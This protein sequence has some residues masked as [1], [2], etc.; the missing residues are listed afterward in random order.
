MRNASTSSVFILT[1]IFAF[2]INFHPLCLQKGNNSVGTEGLMAGVI[3]SLRYHHRFVCL[4]GFFV[5]N[6]SKSRKELLDLFFS[7]F[8]SY[9]VLKVVVHQ[10]LTDFW[11]T[12]SASHLSAKI[13]A[14]SSLL[15]VVGPVERGRQQSSMYTG[16]FLRKKAFP[17]LVKN[18]T[19]SSGGH[20]FSLG[21]FG[22]RV[23]CFGG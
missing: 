10:I 8:L 12:E 6:V 15:V 21:N 3:S 1:L 14:L 19:F 23:I 22:N 9:F 13:F 7:A 17:I 18:K 5:S 11:G 20:V 4:L 2:K 16:I